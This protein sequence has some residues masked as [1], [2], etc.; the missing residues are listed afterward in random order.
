LIDRIQQSR[1][2]LRTR[3][4][5]SLETLWFGKHKGDGWSPKN[6]SQYY[7]IMLTCIFQTT[8]R[9]RHMFLLFHC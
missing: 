2:H 9:I 4:E 6:R 1:F 8:C 3:E 5:P 7:K